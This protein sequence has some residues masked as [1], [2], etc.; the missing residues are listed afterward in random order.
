MLDREEREL[1]PNLLAC[2]FVVICVPFAI[3]ALLW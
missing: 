1:D 3:L 2:I